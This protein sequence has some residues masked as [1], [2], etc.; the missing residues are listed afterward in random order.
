MGDR[1]D[2]R[3]VYTED[4]ATRCLRGRVEDNLESPY[5]VVHRRDGKVTINRSAVVKIEYAGGRG[6]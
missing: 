2:D 5:V 6:P 4:G 1:E 3:V